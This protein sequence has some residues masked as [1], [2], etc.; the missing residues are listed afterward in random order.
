MSIEIKGVEI[1]TDDQGY[2]MDPELWDDEVAE[3]IAQTEGV[4]LGDEHRKIL[5]FIRKYFHEYRVAADARFVIKY[6]A[7]ELGYRKNARHRLYEL[8]PYGYMQ[9]VCKIAG[10]RRPRAWSTG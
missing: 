2:L 4:K 10:M 1:E 9:Q 6:L 5:D 7:E 8:F 3:K